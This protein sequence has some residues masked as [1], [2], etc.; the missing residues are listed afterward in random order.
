MAPPRERKPK[1][2][3][4]A[5]EP[6][7]V[8]AAA[9]DAATAEQSAVGAVDEVIVEDTVDDLA[10][11]HPSEADT[12]VLDVP[13]EPVSTATVPVEA[14][15]VAAASA[16]AD[17]DLAARLAR[18]EAENAALRSKL[19]AAAAAKPVATVPHRRLRSWTAVAL[20]AIG[21]LLAP[22]GLVAHWAQRTLTDTDRYLATVAPLADDPQVQSAIISRT[23]T[24]VMSNVDVSAV[25]TELQDFLVQQGAP[26]RLTERIPLLDAPLTSGVQTLVTKVV[27]RFVES[28]AF[29]SLWTQVNRT[30]QTQ[31]VAV[32][33][34]DPN[35]VIQ[36]DD[37]GY[38]SLQ[39]G[40]IIDIVKT[41]LVDAGLGIASAIPDVNPTVPVAQ[42]DSLAQLRTAYNILDTLGDWLPWIALLFLAAGVLVSTRRMRAT[43]VAALSLVAGMALL[44]IGLAVGKEAILGSLPAT[45][46]GGAVTV[47]FE[48]VVH[49]MKV[50]LR[51]VAVVGL[52][53][54]FFA[55]IAGGSAAALATRRSAG[56]GFETVKSWGRGK[57]VDTGGFG[58]WLGSQRVLIRWV[59]IAI[60]F[61]VI[62]AADTPTAGLV[63]WTTIGVVVL[64]GI[65]ELLSASPAVVAES[66]DPEVRAI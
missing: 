61:L 52:V 55:F 28:D 21:A 19:G 40:P 26:D 11:A 62:V 53:V 57:G 56:A 15:A 24:A 27:T 59:L 44:A 18:L 46:S 38:L 36:L 12:I 43:V 54:A 39:L 14:V 6:V 32:L 7:E 66:E 63:I 34:G 5:A 29:T 22:L 33:N 50:A 30:A 31:I 48:T 45:A 47:I 2:E 35:T 65:V 9:E 10:D 1:V 25:T 3:P 60:G 42:A 64:I 37:D 13:I 4:D 16:G 58:I 41:Q 51:M 20:I 17:D 23:V 8:P 49:F